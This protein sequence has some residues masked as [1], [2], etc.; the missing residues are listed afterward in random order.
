MLTRIAMVAMVYRDD[1]PANGPNRVVSIGRSFD[2][3]GGV[4]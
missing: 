3:A 2:K 4:Q 1:V